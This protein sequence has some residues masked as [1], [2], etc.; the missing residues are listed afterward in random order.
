MKKGYWYRTENFHWLR[1][2][3]PHSTT[4]TKAYYTVPE[5]N[6][7]GNGTTQRFRSISI[8]ESSNSP[9]RPRSVSRFCS[10]GRHACT[11]AH[12]K[13][14]TRCLPKRD[15]VFEKTTTILPSAHD[16]FSCVF[17]TFTRL[18]SSPGFSD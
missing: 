17:Q 1:F 6:R 3:L 7:L 9:V 18:L 5:H 10:V 13:K 16:V 4:Y 12:R 11:I 8:R 14:K 15:E 2:C